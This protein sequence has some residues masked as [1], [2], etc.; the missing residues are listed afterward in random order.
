MKKEFIPYEQALALK[1]LGFDE[2]CF[3]LWNLNNGKHEVDIIGVCK[4]SKEFKYREVLAPTFSQ[5]F[6][7]FREKYDILATVYS[8]ASGYLYEWSDNVGGTHRG[9]SNDEGP[10]NG[11]VWDTYEEAELACLKK[12]IEIA[13]SK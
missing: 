8:N 12:L 1:E 11:G 3:G 9:W 2:P 7:W 10:N 4:Y 5:A 6:K 13:Q